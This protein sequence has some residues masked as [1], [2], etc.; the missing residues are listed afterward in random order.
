M[1]V[2][3]FLHGW[4]IEWHGDLCYCRKCILMGYVWTQSMLWRIPLW[5]YACFV[6]CFTFRLSCF[7]LT[8]SVDAVVVCCL[9]L[10]LLFL[11]FI[12]VLLSTI[13][14]N[15][16]FFAICL[17][18]IFHIILLYF[19]NFHCTTTGGCYI[20]YILNNGTH[21][22]YITPWPFGD[23]WKLTFVSY[24]LVNYRPCYQTHISA[25]SME[26]LHSPGGNIDGR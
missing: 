21:Y 4:L 6:L 22:S 5:S 3:V 18:Y 25:W 8:A 16:N 14:K 19:N 7:V 1:G 12:L 11:L 23:L 24:T 17:C 10:Y 15:N 26:H 13:V 9:L 20:E 2:F